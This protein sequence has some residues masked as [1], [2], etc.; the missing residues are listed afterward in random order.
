MSISPSLY[1]RIG[2]KTRQRRREEEVEKRAE[3]AHSNGVNSSVSESVRPHLSEFAVH[4]QHEL[5]ICT[6]N[7][8][9]EDSPAVPKKAK[10]V[11]ENTTKT[12]PVNTRMCILEH[13][14]V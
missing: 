7:D 13:T 2:R 11:D 5:C 8:A 14:H 10:V 9:T 3:D 1:F 4:C 6:Q 12:A